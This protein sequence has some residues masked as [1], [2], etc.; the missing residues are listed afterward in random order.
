MAPVVFTR[1][2]SEMRPRS[3]SLLKYNSHLLGCCCFGPR[4]GR[5]RFF[6]FHVNIMGSPIHA[7]T[8]LLANPRIEYRSVSKNAAVPVARHT[9]AAE[10][11][12]FLNFL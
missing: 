9:S 4:R 7:P 12:M 11:L 5:G 10:A 2:G 3:M 1:F 8:L 6:F